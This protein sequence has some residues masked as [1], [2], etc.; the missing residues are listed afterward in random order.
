MS[1]PYGLERL[2]PEW[3]EWTEDAVHKGSVI[4]ALTKLRWALAEFR[5]WSG[6]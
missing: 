5:V 1:D 4:A 6:F 2:V 3:P